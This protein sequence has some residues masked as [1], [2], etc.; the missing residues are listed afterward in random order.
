M[1]IECDAIETRGPFCPEGRRYIEFHRAIRTTTSGGEDE[2]GGED[3]GGETGEPINFATA[4]LDMDHVYG[5]HPPGSSD[6][7]RYRTGSGGMMKLD[8]RTRLPPVNDTTG[9]YEVNDDV[10]RHLP[11]SLALTSTFLHHHNVRSAHHGALHPEWNDEAIFQE[12]RM[13]VIAVYQNMFEEYYVPAVLGFPLSGYRG[14]DPDVDASIDVFFSTCSFRFGHSGV[15][16]GSRL[17]DGRWEPLPQ[18]PVLMRDA[19]NATESFVRAIDGPYRRRDRPSPAMAAVI[20]GLTHDATRAPDASFVDDMSLFMANSVVLN[21]QR[22]RDNGL[23][24]YNDAREW[25]GLEPAGSY[26]DLA[27]GDA[28]VAGMLEGLYGEGNVD[29]VDAYVGAMMEA[30]ASGDTDLGPLNEASVRDQWERLRNGDRLYYRARLKAEEI[31]NLPTFADLVREAWGADEMA[32]F[33][34][35]IFAVVGAGGDRGGVVDNTGGEMELLDG[36]L[37]IRWK[38]GRGY[39]D[40]TMIAPDRRVS[41]GY[42]GLGWKSNIMKGAE[43]WFCVSRMSDKDDDETC[44]LDETPP[45]K[46]SG[47]RGPF[48][49]CVAD[50]ERHVA[51]DCDRTTRENYLMVLNSCASGKRSYVTVRARLCPSH[52]SEEERRDCFS[53]GG[54]MQFIAAY[55]P[56]DADVAHGFSR[57]N[58]G[59]ANL[60]IGNVS[61]CSDDSAKAGLFALHGAVLLVAWLLLAP[62]A[63]YVVRYCKGKLWR[64]KVHITLVGVIIGL[65]FTLVFAAV[66]SVEGTSFGTADARSAAPSKHKTIGLSIIC[67]IAFMVVTG[68]RVHSLQFVPYV[69]PYL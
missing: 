24:S 31:P 66:V 1:R 28:A 6:Y 47:D 30:P 8:D 65:M 59:S 25:F 35:E 38:E 60:A 57:R 48:S 49:C 4:W 37:E 11:M 2:D 27:G 17:L 54:D 43:I 21:V 26:L 46:P 3:C 9:L 63:M 50:G 56:D 20:R 16:G 7:L 55:N 39:I 62:I 19:Y 18:D 58:A 44:D 34:D 51:P 12:A 40:F 36:D 33:P 64:L 10:M 61:T 67:C 32:H 69:C 45:D 14:Y 5:N 41:G 23:P 22:G 13:D 68:K 42:I 53:H 52:S 15:S 29:D